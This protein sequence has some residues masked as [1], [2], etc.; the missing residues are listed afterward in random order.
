[1]KSKALVLLSS[2]FIL[3]ACVVAPRRGGGVEV[4]PILPVLVELDVG[5]PYY[6]QGGYQYFYSDE[7]WRYATSR[8]GPWMDYSR[9]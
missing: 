5:Q 4:V 3:T 8:N 9:A 6:A 2:A 1:M 7:R